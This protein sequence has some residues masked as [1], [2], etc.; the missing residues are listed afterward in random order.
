MKEPISTLMILLVFS[1]LVVATSPERQRGIFPYAYHQETLANGL[2]VIIIPMDSPGLVA[3]YSVVRTGSRDEW[4]PGHSGF[5]HFFEHMM[6][7]GTEKYPGP[8]YDRL[9]TEMGADAN[10]YTSNDIT[11][12]HLVLAKGDLEKVMELESDRFQN[13][14]YTEQ[15]FKTEAGAVYGEYLK[16]LSNPWMVLW[17]K[18]L[19]TAFDVHTYKHTT[20]GFRKDI[21]AMPTMYEYSKSFFQRYYRPENVVLLLVGDL[22]PATTIPL[23]KQYYGNWQ[24]GYVPPQIPPEPEQNQE[25]YAEVS[26]NGKTLPILCIAYKS[27]AFDPKSREMATCY[28]MGDLIFGETSE[29]YKKLMLEEQRVQSLSADFS[30]SRDPEL[31]TIYT[32]IKD[33]NDIEGVKE[34]IYRAIEFFQNNL[35]DQTRLEDQK[36]H[37]KYRFLMGLDTPDNVAGRLARIIA[38]TG[39]IEAIDEL[40]H[41]FDQ[42]TPEDIIQA[43]NKFLIPQKRTVVL[44][45]EGKR[46]E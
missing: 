24:K 40:Y 1:S 42:V 23:V 12:Y 38:M 32:M 43:A 15:A 10:A 29:L 7:R 46:N 25:R 36:R 11:C 18:L 34:E 20:I 9:V 19:D 16:S 13:L 26:Y 5:A 8:V 30:S 35:V 28:L 37:V 45:R 33:E 14:S 41:Q 3:Y 22:D 2:K 4:E 27:L 44:L 17:E 6:F 31:L 39:G 21:E